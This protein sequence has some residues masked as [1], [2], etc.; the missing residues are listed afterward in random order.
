M[1]NVSNDYINAIRANSRVDDVYG[2]IY[3]PDN[4]T[5][6]LTTSILNTN[7]LKISR[8]CVDS[9]ELMF[10][11]CYLGI[12]DME[13]R[14]DRSRYEFFGAVISLT[15]KI[16][17]SGENE[18][19]VWEEVPLGVYT[20]AEA[21]VGSDTNYI[22][23]SAYDNIQ[24]L[25]VDWGD[26]AITGDAW[27]ILLEIATDTGLELAFQ[28]SELTAFPN[29]A[30]VITLNSDSG[31]ASYRD[32]VKYVCQ[33]LCCFA[34]ATR[35]GKLELRHFN[36]PVITTLDRSDR[37]SIVVADYECHYISLFVTGMQGTYHDESDNPDEFG[38]TMTM[39]DVPAFDYGIPEVLTTRV[40]A[41]FD[42]LYG[43][44][45]TP[46]EINMPG[47]PAFD[48]A[49]RV[50]IGIGTTSVQTIITEYEWRFR[51]GMT[52][53]SKGI[54]PYLQ[55]SDQNQRTARIQSR[56]IDA[57]KL[58]AYDFTNTEDITIHDTETREIARCKIFPMQDTH[59]VFMATILVHVDSDSIELPITAKTSG[60]TITPIYDQH[61]NPLTLTSSADG[62][63]SAKIWYTLDG[64]DMEY[65]AIDEL[66]SGDHI[67]TVVYPFHVQSAQQRE[68][69]IFMEAGNGSIF[70]ERSSMQATIIG[71]NLME[72]SSFDGNL[73]ASDVI[74]ALF[75]G[76]FVVNI[77]DTPVIGFEDVSIISTPN[78]VIT[79]IF[80]GGLS[81]S[82]T[83]NVQF[84]HE[85][86]WSYWVD[87]EG[88][89]MTDEDDN[90]IIFMGID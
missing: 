1:Y 13:I 10:G 56:I 28:E 9:D 65:E 54:N 70:I 3:F 30:D 49:D 7:S 48:C 78:D 35:D 40:S 41:M 17:V 57:N 88:D 63:T 73:E 71:Q 58:I 87:D 20:V 8:Q 52:L 62:Q 36:T 42:Y 67:I 86:V 23:V 26:K 83:E 74:T 44:R 69:K 29:Y 47:D 51:D 34:Q 18:E 68:W 82:L 33:M 72:G 32:A 19:R 50:A 81:V 2:T 46:V 12:L 21:E 4:S 5:Q 66:H 89:Y 90:A 38:L 15:Y 39:G 75:D 77:A 14:T 11:G 84:F 55:V 61:G 53:I 76:G 6:N 60:G 59:V 24:L 85:V 31:C 80:G 37:Y 45:Y 43:I 16:V 22:R 64:R 25:D 79:A 27:D